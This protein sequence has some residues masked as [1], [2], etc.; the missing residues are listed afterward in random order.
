MTLQRVAQRYGIGSIY[1][2]LLYINS[3]KTV[4]VQLWDGI[5]QSQNPAVPYLGIGSSGIVICLIMLG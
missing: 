1:M 3:T 4:L 5:A 2:I